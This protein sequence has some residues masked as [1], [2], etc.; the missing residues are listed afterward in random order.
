MTTYNTLFR[1]SLVVL[2]A[3]AVC[4]GAI[5]HAQT[6]PKAPAAA[7]PAKPAIGAAATANPPAIASPT[8]VVP[9]Q[10]TVF[11]QRRS[12]VDKLKAA[13]APTVYVGFMPSTLQRSD[14]FYWA[15]RYWQVANHIT[16]ASKVIFTFIPEEDPHTLRNNIRTQQYKW[17]YVPPTMAVIAQENGYTPVAY[18][19]RPYE[20]V[21]VV[22]A[23]NTAAPGVLTGKRVGYLNGRLDEY[24]A[25]YFLET[26]LKS[27][28][29]LIPSG[30]GDYN[31]LF[32]Q[33]KTQKL[34]AVAASKD[35]AKAWVD[36]NNPDQWKILDGFGSV[37]SATF[38]VHSS[39]SNA[40]YENISKAIFSVPA[41][42]VAAAGIKMKDG[43]QV[44]APYARDQ[45]A[46]MRLAMSSVETDYGR[47]IYN[48]RAQKYMEMHDAFETRIPDINR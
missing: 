6:A 29:R 7:V 40:D 45:L 33:L 12:L 19:T 21:F 4:I 35:S 2:C 28:A 15:T 44:F 31:T 37:P 39:V 36:K 9:A 16:E 10:E 1:R 24:F 48:P 47:V 5:V 8:A 41:S 32:N 26:A 11:S 27:K 38:L 20:T 13:N 43:E 23:S 30:S 17:L 25:P 18:F 14:A 34:D 22:P 3:S 42:A 46:W